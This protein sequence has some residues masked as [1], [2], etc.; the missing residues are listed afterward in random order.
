MQKYGDCSRHF[1]HIKY[2]FFGFWVITEAEA[3]HLT[4]AGPI[5]P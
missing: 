4:M 2:K 1:Q 3:N 5:L